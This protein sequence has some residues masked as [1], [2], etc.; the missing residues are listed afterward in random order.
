MSIPGIPIP[1]M[2]MPGLAIP[3]CPSIGMAIPIGLPIPG[4]P[5]PC[6]SDWPSPSGCPLPRDL[7]IVIGLA[8][9]IGLPMPWDWPSPSGLGGVMPDPDVPGMF[10]MPCIMFCIISVISAAGRF[11]GAGL[12]PETP[13]RRT[14]QPVSSTCL[15]LDIELPLLVSILK[16]GL[17]PVSLRAIHVSPHTSIK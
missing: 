17:L 5:S 12:M 15:N 11:L 2:P 9:A 6:P 3:G 7:P 10:C 13:R 14:V 8:I 16:P 1:G 4:C